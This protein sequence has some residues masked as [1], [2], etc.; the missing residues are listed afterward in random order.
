MTPELWQRLKP[1][2]H[3]ALQQGTEDRAAFVDAAC[4]DDLELKTHLKQLLEAEQREN[5]SLDA[6]LAHI[7]DF[8]DDKVARSQP[9][10]LVPGRF[11]LPLPMIGQIISHYRIIEMLGGGGMGVVYKAEDTSLGRYVA[12]KFLPDHLA[13]DP[14]V[15]KRFR[16]EARA[17]SALNH[18]HICTIYEIGEQDGKVFIAMELMEGATLK[19]RMIGGPLRFEEVLEWGGEIGDALAA[20]H[21]KGIVHR[22]IKPANIFV[23][24]RGH[25]KILD[26]GLAKLMP[27][28]P[29]G[30]F[31]T[32]LTAS[33]T[34]PLT[35]A[36]TVMGTSA[37]MSPEQVRGEEM[38]SRTDL[39]SFG[40]VL[41]EMVTGVVPFR[42]ETHG[43]IAEA[44]LNRTPVPP[45]RLNPDL[46]PKLE[47][48]INKALEKDRKLRYQNAADL[49]TDLRR[50]ARDSNR[51]SLDASSSRQEQQEAKEQQPEKLKAWRA[52][53]YVAA[54][55]LV[56]TIVAAFLFRRPPPGGVPP[57]S[58]EWEQL[59]F[60]TDSAVYPTL[61]PDGRMLAF[62]RA[63][64][65]FL[66]PG[67]VY[68][69]LLPGGEPVQL[70]HDSKTK[71]GLSFSPDNSRIAYSIAE[72]W[73][74]WEVPVLGGEPHLMLPNASSLTWIEGG[75]RL[76]FS[77]IKEGLHMAVVTTNDDRA[78]SRDVYVPAG[79]RS[80]AHHSYLSPDGRWVLV[81][82]MDSRS[83]IIPCRIVPFQGTSDVRVVGPPAGACLSGAWSPDGKWIYLTAK[84]DDFHIWRQR[85]PDGK[86]EQFTFGPTSQEGIAM[87]PDGK[88]LITSVGSQDRSVWLH[89]KDGDHPISFEGNTSLPRFSSDGHSLYFLKTNGQTGNDEL[90]IKDLD[91]G[92]EE[93]TLKDYPMQ[94]YSAGRDVKQAYSVSRDGKEVAFAMKDQSGHSNLWIAPISRRSSP[95]RIFSEAVEDSPFFLP[96]GDLIF[97]AI[98]GGS[99]FLYRMKIDGTGRRK[100]T[101]ERILDIESVSPDGRWVVVGAPNPD[102]EYTASAKAFPVDGGASV[103][104]CVG[105]CSL[106]W[107]TAGKYAL[108]SFFA[109]GGGSYAT[110]VMHDLGLPKLPPAGLAGSQ[111]FT[112]AKTTIA[113]PWFV[114][115]AVSPTVYAYTRE[116]TRRNLYR[117]QLP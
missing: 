89:D 1:L 16:K 23:T 93:R 52:Y 104:V 74:T 94:E 84:T 79:K 19:H 49:Q 82:E 21:S 111:D 58:K 109:N 113:L 107:D 14:Q 67:D 22:D 7:D 69:K 51:D 63:G 80:M 37:Y 28:R 57:P 24:D 72:P 56:L 95:V 9:D 101:P 100:I 88:S 10:E 68:V 59:T 42:G 8:L 66:A 12:L 77:E 114:Q 102:E 15:L 33:Q 112:N 64:N 108:V 87:A 98:E 31:S 86:P 38:D 61:S 97:R 13:Q 117:I 62:I 106:N 71:V 115:S 91:S 40:V 76:L 27:A 30:N 116:N 60:F 20:A 18:P 43:V 2:F 44:I 73:D 55:V 53:F 17:A 85:F 41:Y 25:V 39:F 78:N 103:P 110:P 45:V 46:S 70:T 92:K 96:D 75:R 65:S 3:A 99:N 47:E 105:Y 48:I 5:G 36:G 54:A 6:P 81:V 50:L 29:G 26:F 35:Q 11:R 90:W 4:G 34:G 83:E 32:M